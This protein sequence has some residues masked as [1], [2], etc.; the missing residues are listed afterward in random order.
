[1]PHMGLA[2]SAF[3]CQFLR[4]EFTF[5]ERRHD[6]IQFTER[7]ESR[8]SCPSNIKI[9]RQALVLVNMSF[10]LCRQGFGM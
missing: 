3:P 2:N 7:L 1:M 5:F 9:Y 10:I 6:T 8:Y 4:Q